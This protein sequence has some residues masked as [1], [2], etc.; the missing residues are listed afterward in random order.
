MSMSD[1]RSAAALDL[2]VLASGCRHRYY[3][4]L[5]AVKPHWVNVAPCRQPD[6]L[7]LAMRFLVAQGRA[8]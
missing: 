3:T 4:N 5:M 6:R 1:G 2:L 8:I 7:T